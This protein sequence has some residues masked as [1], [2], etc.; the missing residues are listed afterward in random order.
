[1]YIQR[2]NLAH[3]EQASCILQA[4]KDSMQTQ[5]INQWDNEYPSQN[6]LMEDIN[7]QQAFGL[8][9]LD[10]LLGYVVLNEHQ[11]Q[12]YQD[13]DWN[14]SAHA[15]VIHRLFI[16]PTAQGKGYSSRLLYF[17]ESYAKAFEYDAIRLDAYSLN[18]T[19][20]TLYEKKKYSKVGQVNFR[21]GIFN[22]YEKQI[23]PM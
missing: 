6:T 14:F 16:A 4:V 8:F 22:C 17:A 18:K 1:M 5:G 10:Q 13:L 19:A 3:I 11:D 15:L 2:L 21:K 23:Q 12:E 20:N 7:K 9:S